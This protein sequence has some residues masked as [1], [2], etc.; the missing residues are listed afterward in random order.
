ME[1]FATFLLT[2]CM[3]QVSSP[4]RAQPRTGVEKFASFLGWGKSVEQ[5]HTAARIGTDKGLTWWLNS[6]NINSSQSFAKKL[7]QKRT[8][9]QKKRFQNPHHKSG[10]RPKG[11]LAI[12]YPS[13][14]AAVLQQHPQVGM[15]LWAG[16]W[17]LLTT[18]CLWDERNYLYH[19]SHH[20]LSQE[21]QKPK[22]SYNSRK[23]LWRARGRNTS[24]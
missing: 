1:I 2:I 19:C 23:T 17:P 12:R 22:E 5:P 21:G 18:A 14:L 4:S 6:M 16:R 9:K 10:P 8:R 3:T 13:Q 24:P 15:L 11:A 20:Q 7:G